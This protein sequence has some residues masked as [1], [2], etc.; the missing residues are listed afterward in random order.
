MFFS[1]ELSVLAAQWVPEG[2][3]PLSVYW[4]VLCAQGG[5][6][7]SQGTKASLLLAS[8]KLASR[9]GREVQRQVSVIC[10]ST[11]SCWEGACSALGEPSGGLAW[12]TG[13]EGWP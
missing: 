7:R 4:G 13:S 9:E 6:V 3:V 2:S 11:T 12:A 8:F 1:T 5:N 10:V